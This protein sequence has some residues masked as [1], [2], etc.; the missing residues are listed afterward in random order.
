MIRE[1]REKETTEGSNGL[2]ELRSK[3]ETFL[4]L[5]E[6]HTRRYYIHLG[7][8]GDMIYRYLAQAFGMEEYR[9]DLLN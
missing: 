6:V 1:E 2:L 4:L 8:G 7:E 3:N 9:N 5:Q